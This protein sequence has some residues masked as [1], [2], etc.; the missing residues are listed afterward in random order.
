MLDELERLL[1]AGEKIP[2]RLRLPPPVTLDQASPGTRYP[3]IT[4]KKG[5]PP[6]PRQYG[7]KPED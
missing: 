3:R 6:R 5:K 4:S 1:R 7:F 2:D